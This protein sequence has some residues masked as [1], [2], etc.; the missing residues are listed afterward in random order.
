M[1]KGGNEM[2]VKEVA[3]LVGI[4]VRTLHHYDEIS[5]L[6][7][8]ETTLSGYRMYSEENL[9]MLQ[10][11][12]FFRELGFPLKQIRKI[13]ESPEFDRL[14]ALVLQRGM[15]EDKRKKLDQMIETIDQTIMYRKGEATMT[16]EEKFK[17]FDFSNNPYEQEARERWG[18]DSVDKLNKKLKSSEQKEALANKCNDLYKR[19]ADIRKSSPSSAEAQ[20]LIGEWYRLLNNNFG[21]YSLD[22]FKGLGQMYVTDERFT[23][24]I[25]QHGEGLAQFMAD[26]MI[27]YADN[28]QR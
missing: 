15:L 8:E 4:S 19:L 5:L 9:E 2:K 12:L 10:Q 6:V 3:D 16:N 13:L 14:E 25:D 24:N 11:I 17:G 1:V 22:A 7:P 18:N 20:Q 28:Q 21:N 27:I 26:A 23:E